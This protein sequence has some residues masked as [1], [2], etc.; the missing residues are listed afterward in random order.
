MPPG[1][2]P[3]ACWKYLKPNTGADKDKKS[4]VD[5]FHGKTHS[6]NAPRAKLFL[7]FD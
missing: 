7:A 4:Y 1:R 3:D 5:I 6:D 2:A